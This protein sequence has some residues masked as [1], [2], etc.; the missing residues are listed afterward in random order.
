MFHPGA[1][2]RVRVKII[3]NLEIYLQS[4]ITQSQ[5]LIETIFQS[6]VRTYSLYTFYTIS[7]SVHQETGST[8]KI[9]VGLILVAIR[10]ISLLLSSCSSIVQCLLGL[11]SHCTIVL[12][13]EELEQFYRQCPLHRCYSSI[14]NLQDC[15]AC[16][17]T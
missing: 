14:Y 10:L 6:S 16:L 15:E 13:L 5:S 11:V 1:F 17:V 12:Q 8:Y 7:E 4:L 3:F 2:V 9:M